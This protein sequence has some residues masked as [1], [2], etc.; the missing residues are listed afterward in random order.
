MLLLLLL[1]LT[2][3]PAR[4]DY[5]LADVRYPAPHCGATSAAPAL[6][7]CL[8][9][10]AL[11]TDVLARTLRLRVT[12]A[13]GATFSCRLCDASAAYCAA[14]LNASDASLARDVATNARLVLLGGATSGAPG[15]LALASDGTG[16]LALDASV[17]GTGRVTLGAAF[18]LTL[19][20][21]P[22]AR[23][24]VALATGTPG[25]PAIA[26]NA[27]LAAALGVE[28]TQLAPIVFE[29]RDC[30]ALGD[31]PVRNRTVA[32]ETTPLAWYERLLWHD[33][34][35]PERLCSVRYDALLYES[36]LYAAVCLASDVRLS[37]WHRAAVQLVA[38]RLASVD[39]AD[40]DLLAALDLVG[41][42]CDARWAPLSAAGEA[43]V[44]PL[45][46]RLEATL[47][48]APANASERAALCASV[49]RYA[50]ENPAPVFD[51]RAA[52]AAWY[53][54]PFEL[55]VRPGP[56]MALNAT[57]LVAALALLALLLV[58][59]AVSLLFLLL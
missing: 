39:A 9:R 55:L 43:V 54:A 49:A 34:V 50:A 5:C 1:A 18:V 14:P 24:I 23:D 32:L 4:A 44:A 45:L 51:W 58:A 6:S 2:L 48:L 26:C 38:R 13:D 15:A 28:C 36:D 33:V 30:L 56:G 11:S 19:A 42:H 20:A 22:P 12:L 21:L 31:G 40:A 35:I 7:N 57:L 53:Y 37:A 46:A 3:A 29:A 8:A 52:R 17:C 41:R 10:L 16:E 59:G 25:A 27:S 47:P